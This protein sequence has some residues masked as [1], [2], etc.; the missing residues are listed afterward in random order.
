MI[1]NGLTVEN[2][3]NIKSAKLDFSPTVNIFLGQNAQGK[4][5]LL[6]SI[7][8]FSGNRSFRNSKDKEF[9]NFNANLSKI[10]IDFFK[11]DREQSAEIII[12]ESK[13]AFLNEIPLESISKFLSKINMTVF[14]PSHLSL[15]S[16]G[17]AERRNFLDSAIS[18]IKPN[19][20]KLVQN[21]T[22]AVA[23]R[24]KVLKDISYH[25]QLLDVLFIYEEQIA[26]YG[27]KIIEN[28][29]KYID[30]LQDVAKDIYFGISGQKEEISIKYLTEVNDENMV[31]DFKDKLFKNR[32]DD[33][34][35]GATSIG[36]HRDDIEININGISA[37]TFGSQGQKRS[38]VLSMK[39]AES[40]ILTKVFG[41]KPIILLDDVMSELDVTRQEY[42]LNYIE[43]SQIF[44]TSCEKTQAKMLKSAKVFNVSGGKIIEEI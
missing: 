21:Y 42:L 25:S 36:P 28:R 39:L 35:H 17:P 1:I 20:L 18:S 22:S 32:K 31:E 3:R 43:G 29:K 10:N 16:D 13:K 24:N 40:E 44:I 19:Y 30:K 6:E 23:E 11:D 9:I 12:G 5:N 26:K 2:F 8:L 7:W 33:I 14:V 34:F 4:T 41:E 15:I 27:S 37:R 38:A